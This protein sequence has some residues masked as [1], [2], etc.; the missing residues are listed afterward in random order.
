MSPD[1]FVTYL[2]DRSMSVLFLIFVTICVLLAGCV[3][4]AL[5]RSNRFRPLIK[6]GYLVLAW[7]VPILGALLVMVGGKVDPLEGCEAPNAEA[8]N[9]S[10]ARS[11]DSNMA[12]QHADSPDSGNAE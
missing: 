4:H 7:G 1:C 2:P 11:H 3:T 10:V 12:A 5:M 8:V 9:L 6:S